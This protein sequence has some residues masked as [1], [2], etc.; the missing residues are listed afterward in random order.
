MN[1]LQDD[2][3]KDKVSTVQK[4]RLGRRYGKQFELGASWR[5]DFFGYVP[6]DEGVSVVLTFKPLTEEF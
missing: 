1:F 4:E 5:Q 2:N 6:K 3:S